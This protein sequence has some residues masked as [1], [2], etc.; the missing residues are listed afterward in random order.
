M[1]MKKRILASEIVS[2]PADGYLLPVIIP[3]DSPDVE[4]FSL[5]AKKVVELKPVHKPTPG[6]LYDFI[7]SNCPHYDEKLIKRYA[8]IYPRLL[9]VYEF[10]A[11]NKKKK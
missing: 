10:I 1:K 2:P 11:K 8:N 4:A 7:K 6:E 9:Q 3:R 5:F